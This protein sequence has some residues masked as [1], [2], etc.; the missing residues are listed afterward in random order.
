R[1]RYNRLLTAMIENP[2]I[3]GI[4]IDESTAIL[5]KNGKAEVVG[6]S[7]VIVFSNPKAS[8]NTSK[9]KLAARGLVLDIYLEGDKF[10]LSN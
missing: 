3:K 10:D 2:V 4:G 1:S 5:V 9:G 6:E 7:Q 8:K